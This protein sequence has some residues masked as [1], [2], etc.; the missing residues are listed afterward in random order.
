MI[1]IQIQKNGVKRRCEYI[2]R[3]RKENRAALQY[4]TVGFLYIHT[5]ILIYATSIGIVMLRK[6]VAQNDGDE[7]IYIYIEPS[8]TQSGGGGER[9]GER[10]MLL[11]REPQK[12]RR[13]SR[14]VSAGQCRYSARA[15][16]LSAAQRREREG[17][18]Y[19][20]PFSLTRACVC[21]YIYTHLHFCGLRHCG[22]AVIG[23][24]RL[25]AGHAAG[26]RLRD[27]NYT[28]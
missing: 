18:R 23:R 17:R 6:E 27:N 26:Q 1:Y 19:C 4:C 20:A 8:Y 15:E 7:A 21:A 2:C 11:W 10:V 12:P 3:E 16:S 28:W 22:C 9:S 5:Y 13:T 24:V 25:A 14:L